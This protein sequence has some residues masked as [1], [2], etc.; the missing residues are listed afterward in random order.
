M[1]LV[2]D[3]CAGATAEDIS[4]ISRT[5]ARR[6][7]ACE[8]IDRVDKGGLLGETVCP[9][10]VVIEVPDVLAANQAE[11]HAGATCALKGYSPNETTHGRPVCIHE[12]RDHRWAGDSCIDHQNSSV[13]RLPEIAGCV[14]IE[15]TGAALEARVED[16]MGSGWGCEGG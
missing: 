5:H 14:V 10:A 12:K 16:I 6:C 9:N 11:R 13:R 8:S 2:D 3:V 1:N 15:T 4:S 7:N